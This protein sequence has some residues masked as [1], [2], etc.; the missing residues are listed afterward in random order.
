MTAVNRAVYT[1]INAEAQTKAMLLSQP[2]SNLE[3]PSG[4]VGFAGLTSEQIVGCSAM[5]EDSQD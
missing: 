3:S 5:N 1:R 2:A 4:G